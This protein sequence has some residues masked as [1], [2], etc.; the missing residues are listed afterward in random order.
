M[1]KWRALWEEGGST[2]GEQIVTEL[3]EVAWARSGVPMSSKPAVSKSL[4][5]FFRYILSQAGGNDA[6]LAYAKTILERTPAE[7]L[8]SMMDPTPQQ[9]LFTALFWTPREQLRRG[10]DDI[11]EVSQA[12]QLTRVASLL[13]IASDAAE[14]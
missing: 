4:E 9:K 1:V 7:V 3:F 2:S 10:I 14:G 5:K 11:A 13:D 12:K 6:T 8:A